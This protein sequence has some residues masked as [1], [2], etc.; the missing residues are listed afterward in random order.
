MFRVQAERKSATIATS[1][2]SVGVC[3]QV[4]V[5]VSHYH[6]RRVAVVREAE[7]PLCALGESYRLLA[8]AS[9]GQ[10]R[11]L[12]PREAVQAGHSSQLISPSLKD[13]QLNPEQG[14]D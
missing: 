13:A 2:P 7:P 9:W 5:R 10:G 12:S 11:R 4:C 14:S 6:A 8:G 3:E 1:A